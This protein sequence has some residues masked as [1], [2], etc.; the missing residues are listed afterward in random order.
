MHAVLA[1]VVQEPPPRDYITLG[2][3]IILGAPAL[4]SIVVGWFQFV[5]RPKTKSQHEVLEKVRHQVENSHETNLR[6]DIDKLTLTVD[7]IAV[8]VRQLAESLTVV[9]DEIT[10][11]RADIGGL[12]RAVAEVRRDVTTQRNE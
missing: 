6:D 7:G 12:H 11:S 4:S 5:Y 10:T 1:A 9:H 2:G 3:K 8:T